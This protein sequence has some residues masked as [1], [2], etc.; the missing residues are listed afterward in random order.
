MKA[1]KYLSLIVLALS[2]NAC[3]DFAKLEQNPNKATSVPPSLVLRGIQ[4][5]L[6]QDAWSD[7]HRYNQFW[8]SNYNYYDNNEYNWTSADLRFTTLKNIQ[9]MEE[10]ALARDAAA[11]NP[12]AALG[13]F[14]RALAYYEMT[15]LV[16]DLPL[17][18]ALKGAENV[19]PAYDTQ[20]EI[21]AQIL[22][23]LEEANSEL[24]TLITAA[25][26][27]LS[28]DIYFSNDLRAWQRTVNTFKLRVLIALS[29]HDDNATLGIKAKFA[30]VIN[31]PAKYPLMT[32]RDENMQF[33]YN[34]NV[35]LYPFNPSNFGF[36]ATRDNTSATLLGIL[37]SLEDP[38][39][40][41][42]AEPASYYADTLGYGAADFR[43]YVGA[44]AAE[45]LDDMAFKVL[46][47]RYSL[48]NKN[49]WS[50]FT[51]TPTAQ[52]GY[53]EMCFNIAEAANRG[54]VTADAASWYGKGITAAMNAFGINSAADIA[55]YIAKPAVAYK[56]GTD[57]L[58][59]ILSQ[60]YV[61]FFNN[62]GW[63]A[64]FN[65]RR[66]GVPTFDVGSGTG[67]NGKIPVRF[68]YP[69][70]ERSINKTN[71]DAAV[72]RQFDGNDDINAK[73]WLIKD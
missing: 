55:A 58:N 67:A 26:V 42:V 60:K 73:M 56:G 28:G 57:G 50:S 33:V 64:Y 2:L 32:S 25:D 30:D 19:A 72:Q 48:F 1:F 36:V 34:T 17:S 21:F 12:Y 62:S 18:E 70:A 15:S 38:R 53:E 49:Y 6:F 41:V 27:S 23:W 43:S 10:E 59:Q 39:T 40:F 14:Y 9:K 54:W 44:P 3:T 11:V 61:A 52:V 13:K 24:A 37:T 31:N 7:V 16:G 71:Y 45:G 4:T 35:N 5:D 66:T 51:G 69:L 46:K 47:G 63:E 68:Q 65:W 8:L 20:E 29:K 22:T